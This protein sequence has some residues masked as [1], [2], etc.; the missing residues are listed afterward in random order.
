MNEHERTNEYEQKV[1]NIQNEYEKS[2]TTSY[3]FKKFKYS[4]YKTIHMNLLAKHILRYTDNQ[5]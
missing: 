5:I 4:D 2:I 1:P 3:E